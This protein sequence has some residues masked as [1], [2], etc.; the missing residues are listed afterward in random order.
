[1]KCWQCKT[2]LGLV[3]RGRIIECPK[4]KIRWTHFSTTKCT[5][6]NY[7][8]IKDDE[9]VVSIDEYAKPK[10]ELCQENSKVVMST[11]KA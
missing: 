1:M 9:G 7:Y 3:D 10:E 6:P 5:F 11:G 4:C 2:E 8:I